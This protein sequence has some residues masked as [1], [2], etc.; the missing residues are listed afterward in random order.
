MGSLVKITYR[1]ENVE[2]KV[3]VYNYLVSNEIEKSK[4]P[5]A[6]VKIIELASKTP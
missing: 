4:L 2:K 5:S 6:V 3:T 1:K